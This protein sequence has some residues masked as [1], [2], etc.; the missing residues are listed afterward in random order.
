MKI[1]VMGS[2]GVGGYFGVLLAR[3]GQEVT[4]IARGEHLRAMQERGLQVR[5][6]G[7]NLT[8]PVRATGQLSEV[9]PVDLVLFAVKSYS[10]EEAARAALP[11]LA[12]GG[13]A[14]TLQNGIDPHERVAAVVGQG[15]VLAGIV[16]IASRIEEGSSSGPAARSV[17]FLG[18]RKEGARRAP[19]RSK[20]PSTRRGFRAS[21]PRT[22]SWP[23]GR[24]TFSSRPGV[25]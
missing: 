4:F 1:A 19:R 23:F 9:G 15:K 13:S 5:G 25:G 6:V 20:T 22:C 24:S 11:L 7:E 21:F 18:S 16:Q 14:L 8:L 17:P 12:V 10:I 3:S 2:G